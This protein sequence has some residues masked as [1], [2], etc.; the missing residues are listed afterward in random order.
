MN[1]EQSIQLHILRHF[2]RAK[3]AHRDNINTAD[4][5][6]T[7]PQYKPSITEKLPNYRKYASRQ[8]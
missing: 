7:L 1:Q 3:Q 5:A 6:A 2:Q 8:V 4:K